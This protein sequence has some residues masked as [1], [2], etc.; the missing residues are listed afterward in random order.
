VAEPTVSAT[1][2]GADTVAR[3]MHGAAH[4]LRDMSAAHADAADVIAT[5]AQGLAPRLTGALAAETAPASSKEGAGISNALPYF[6]PIHYG[7]AEH[8]ITAQPFVDEAVADTEREWLAIY[9][10]A[11]QEAADSVRG[12]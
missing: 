3:T 10:H 11:A 1:V 12:A 5:A 7:W 6:G 2:T 9:Q 8:N 4:D